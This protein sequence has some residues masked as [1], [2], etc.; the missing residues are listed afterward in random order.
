MAVCLGLTRYLDLLGES[1]SFLLILKNLH[2]IVCIVSI[3]TL[4]SDKLSRS[5]KITLTSDKFG[6][7]L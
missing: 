5:F 6:I 4:F 1:I 3:V 7:L 2:T